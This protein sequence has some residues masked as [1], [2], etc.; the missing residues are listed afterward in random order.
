MRELIVRWYEF[1]LFCPIFRT[2]GCRSGPSEPD[3]PPCHPTQGVGSCGYNEVWSYGAK[4]QI[5]LSSLVRLRESVLK[6]YIAELAKNVSARGVPTMRPLWWEFDDP[7]VLDVNDQY[8]LGPRLLIA[9]VV[10][11]GETNRSVI[12]PGGVKWVSFWDDSWHHTG[13]G[14]ILVDAPLGKIPAYWRS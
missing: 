7:N 9:P 12:F 5:I 4:T 11:Q 2:H 8:M 6:P 1:G 10:E 13:G 3:V 14:K